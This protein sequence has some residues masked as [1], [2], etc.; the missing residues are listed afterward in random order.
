MTRTAHPIVVLA[1]ALALLA[2]ACRGP[3]PE[4]G[5]DAFLLALRTEDAEAAW[6]ALSLE[7]RDRLEAALADSPGPDS[8]QIPASQQ[9]FKRGLLRAMRE[10]T[11]VDVVHRSGDRAT[12]EVTDEAGEKQQVQMILEQ[13]R[14]RL[15]LDL[16]SPR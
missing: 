3:S 6:A 15:R 13:G 4:Q 7:T 1:I 5:F 14:W 10:V 11:R 9:L 8:A 2:Q 12:L 16:P